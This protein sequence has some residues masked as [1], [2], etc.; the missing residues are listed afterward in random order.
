MIGE[1]IRRARKAKGLSQEELAVRLNVVRQT[2]SK[3]EKGLSV[4]DADVL[5]QI[6]T[7]LDA[8]VSQ[9]LGA[10]PPGGDVQDLTQQLAQLN[11][12]LA[13]HARRER[14]AQ[15]VN[16][17]R[18][19]VLCLSFLALAAALGVGSETVSLILFGACILA[20]VVIFYRSL[21]LL[22]GPAATHAQLRAVRAVTIF[23]VCLVAALFAAIA[24][25]QSGL[26]S[27]PE[28]AV[29]ALL[30]AA[31]IL[32]LLFFGFISPR[33]P[34]NRY[35]G[36][37]LPWTIRDED[38]WNVAH[39]LL[40]YLALPLALLYPAACWIVGGSVE[41]W[42]AVT[43]SVLLLWVGI[44]GRCP[45]FSFGKRC[46]AGCNAAKWTVL[47]FPRIEPGKIS[48]PSLIQADTAPPEYIGKEVTP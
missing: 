25:H 1:N 26:V 12:L 27:L 37:R 35:T 13:D 14:L 18:G 11:E 33:L 31:V 15:Q 9:L 40:G 10:E 19:A 5:I 2:V 46:A 34:F 4:P 42:A 7:L 21:A 48:H 39:K 44:P 36:F 20:A 43:G 6:A 23:N 16:Q 22:T 28:D 3:W 17:K 32:I 8:P 45:S 38:T 41:A 29:Q 47:I 24:L 30:T